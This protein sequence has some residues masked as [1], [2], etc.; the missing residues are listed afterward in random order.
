MLGT[1]LSVALADFRR[2][3]RS[4]TLPVAGLLTAY[5]GKI[6]LVDGELVVAGSYTGV[7]TAAWYG[8]TVCALGT[9]VLLIV[10][11]PIVRGG[12]THDYETGVSALLA[13]SPLSNTAY[14]F[15]KFLAGVAALSAVTAV[16]AAATTVAFLTNGTGPFDPVGLWGPFVLITGP[17]IALIAAAAVVT[18]VVRPLRGTAGVAVYVVG[19]FALVATG[20]NGTAPIDITGI[21]L[22]QES[23]T[24]QLVA[25]YPEVSRPIEGFAYQSASDG[26]TTF[27]WSGI[28]WT[29]RR[30]VDRLSS[31]AVVGFLLFGS[32]I[33][34]D[35]FDPEGGIIPSVSLGSN[36]GE[37]PP[38]TVDA[39][40]TEA[41]ASATTSTDE[42]VRTLPT[43]EQ[44]RFGLFTATT[45]ELR[46]ALRRQRIWWVGATVVVGVAVFGPLGSA[47]SLVAPLATLLAL[48]ALS[49]MGTRPE[50]E[51]TAQLLFT[52]TSPVGLLVP[53][54]LAGVG[55]LAGLIG[56]TGVRLLLAGQAGAAAG[57]A[58]GIVA[59]PAAALAFGVW[60]GR[61]RVFETLLLVAWYLGPV[62]GLSALDFLAVRPATVAAGVPYA[63][64]AAAPILLAVAALGRR[65]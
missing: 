7:G 35:R 9:T 57:I 18:E 36:E 50:Q 23:M 32:I 6:I 22:L 43:P 15:G 58:G 42:A 45:A 63:Y 54:Y 33:T 29:G 12:I 47:R 62:N 20:V 38:S 40:V 30:L 44:G 27:R 55:V 37:N 19:A 4:L 13:T 28:E 56:A 2:R 8:A 49:A 65:V 25:Q 21:T 48:P 10:G 5:L 17:A 64:L 46:M 24:A 1:A 3:S 31:V 26:T 34:F 11:F 52:T 59:L 53:T 16:L 51:Q 60:T 41:S 14:I 61:P 39:P